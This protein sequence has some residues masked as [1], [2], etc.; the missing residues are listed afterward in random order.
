MKASKSIY[1]HTAIIGQ[2][3]LDVLKN[4]L[5]IKVNNMV[6]AEKNSRIREKGRET[7]GKVRPQKYM[8]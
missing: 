6:S 8:K 3:T 5:K 4:M 1:N 7:S 2:V